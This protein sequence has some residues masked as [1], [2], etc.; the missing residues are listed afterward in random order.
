MLIIVVNNNFED[1]KSKKTIFY[2]YLQF[3]SITSIS[4][5]SYEQAN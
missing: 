1:T 3:E 4:D 5:T 2:A